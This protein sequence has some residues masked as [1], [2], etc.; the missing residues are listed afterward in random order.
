LKF[1]V[2][3]RIGDYTL[4]ARCGEGA[5][6]VVF[7][8]ENMMTRRKV[9]LKIVCGCGKNFDRE[10][11]GL[12]QY[13][14]ICRR[15]DLLQ[16]YHVGT[17]DGF[18]YYTMDAADPLDGAAGYTPKTLA[19]VLKAKGKLPAAEVLRMYGEIASALEVLHR[20]GLVHRDIKPENILWVDDLAVPGDVGLVA[21]DTQTAPAGTPGFMP[22]EVIAG[23]REYEAKDDFYALGK[24]LYCALTGL[25]VAKYPSFP[26]SATLTG[27]GEVIR[28]YTRLCSGEAVKL[29]T[30]RPSA[31]KIVLPAASLCLAAAAFLA[32]SYLGK[33]RRDAP[34][35]EAASA[36]PPMPEAAYVPS[37]EMVELMPELRK[38]YAELEKRLAAAIAAAS[39]VSA[40]ELAEAEKYLARH[41]E[42]PLFACPEAFAYERKR[43]RAE[44]DFDALHRSDPAWCYF[45]NQ[46]EIAICLANTR[47]GAVPRR[48]SV[49]EARRRLS[50]L[51]RRQRDLESAILKK[52]RK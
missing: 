39:D 18:F 46:E 35:P 25:P 22:P 29:P 19:N 6:G 49:A 3:G 28:L 24:V 8:A 40:E 11:K 45:R 4:L 1:D 17:G 9:A 47:E 33:S 26:E 10:L 52:Y 50:D 31:W 38:H 37:P 36:T 43:A 41:P 12:R 13:Q 34:V 15:T 14:Q 16:I 21:G 32:G 20:K 2:G 51:Y 44:K 5:Y 23:V 48:Y 42:H 7:L 27:A 30:K